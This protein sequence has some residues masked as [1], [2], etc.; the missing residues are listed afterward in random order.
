MPICPNHQD[1]E[2]VVGSPRFLVFSVHELRRSH[3]VAVRL[4]FVLDE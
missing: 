3:R 2:I 1:G 4:V